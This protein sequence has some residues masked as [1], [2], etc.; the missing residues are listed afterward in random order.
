M[1]VSHHGTPIGFRRAYLRTEGKPA[2]TWF[3]PEF[4]YT[5]QFVPVYCALAVR[6]HH[7]APPVGRLGD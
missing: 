4:G 6:G 1:I 2:V 7:S 5:Y 3:H